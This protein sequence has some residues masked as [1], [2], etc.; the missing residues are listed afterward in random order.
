LIFPLLGLC[1]HKPKE[2]FKPS[3][4]FDVKEI[5]TQNPKQVGAYLTKYVTR[6]KA[7]FKCQVWNWSKEI[8]ALYTDFYTG[9]EFLE[10]LQRLKGS[11]IKETPW[12]TARCTLSLR[13]KRPCGSMTA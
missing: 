4:A 11:E 8:S 1:P 12:N 5:Q 3:P 9:Y 13:I 10:E 7:E 6:N 2:R